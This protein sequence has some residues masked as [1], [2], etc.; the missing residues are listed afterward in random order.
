MVKI[1]PSALIDPSAEIAEDVTIGPYTVVEAGVQIGAGSAIG[2]FVTLASG[3]RLGRRVRVYNYA[4][5]GTASQDLKHKGET[6]FAEIGDDAIVREYVSVNRGTREGSVTRVG[7]GAVLMAY[8]HVAHECVIDSK[9]ILVN[10]ATLGGEV[11]VGA[12]AIIGGLVGVHQFCRIGAHA[13]VG[14][15]SKVNQDIAPFL[16]ADGH[17]AR[18]FGPNHVGLRRRGFGEAQIADIAR[19]Y[20][21]LFNR[22]RTLEENLALIDQTFGEC[23]IAAQI[24]AFCRT[25][26][27]RGL[28]RPRRRYS[29]A[30]NMPEI[31]PAGD[32]LNHPV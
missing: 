2:A 3:L 11:H 25:G 16:L 5:L 6:S 12:H 8:A 26:G 28:A 9:A 30:P 32:R 19:V 21:E 27:R 31:Y 4:C 13:I 7:A 1:H 18:P 24:T 29:H 23:G 15:N 14:A 17:P 10:A 22:G 20:R